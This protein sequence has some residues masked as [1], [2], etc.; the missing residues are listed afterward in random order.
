M[1][2]KEKGLEEM[3]VILKDLVKDWQHGIL[4]ANSS[5]IALSILVN[6][7][8]PSKECSEWAIRAAKKWKKSKEV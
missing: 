6:D 7:K 2:V 1:K 8:L 5:M 3:M 4:T